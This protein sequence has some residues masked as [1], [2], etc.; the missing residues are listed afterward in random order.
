MPRKLSRKFVER[1]W[2]T[3]LLEPWYPNQPTKIGEVWLE[4][5]D[6]PPLLVKFIFTC[7]A[8]SIQVHPNDEQAKQAGH[9]RGKTEMW[10]VLRA[11][12]AATIGVGLRSAVTPDQ[13]RAACESGDVERLLD[14]KT[15]RAG[16]A[17]LVRAGTIHAIGAGVVLCEI[18]QNSDVTY[19]LYDYGRPRQLHL[20]EGMKVA[21]PVPH[22][23]ATPV[24]DLGNGVSTPGRMR[25][26]RDRRNRSRIAPRL[27]T[28]G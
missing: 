13:L 1:V 14:W 15:A 8:L 10:V 11:D 17:I 27:L 9:A 25:I 22:P 6:D 18:Q 4:T 16:D 20:D 21:H 2:G 28:V 7:E 23:G 26:L 12:P 3:T 5:V 24:V 19:R